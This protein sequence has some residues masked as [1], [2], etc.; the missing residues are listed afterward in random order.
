MVL[1]QLQGQWC[2][3]PGLTELCGALGWPN[4][5]LSTWEYLQPISTQS[6]VETTGSP[7]KA[8]CSLVQPE[9]GWH[10]LMAA[11][12]D[13]GDAAHPTIPFPGGS[14]LGVMPRYGE[15]ANSACPAWRE[16]YV[17]SIKC[18]EVIFWVWGRAGGRRWYSMWRGLN[19]FWNFRCLGSKSW[20]FKWKQRCETVI[21]H[22]FI[23][24]SGCWWSPVFFFLLRDNWKIFSYEFHRRHRTY[25]TFPHL[26][27]TLSTKEGI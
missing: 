11:D 3:R 27:N 2:G 13:P 26:Q 12:T 20:H 17:W 1:E 6:C 22:A 10:I 16:V 24:R 7:G 8:K 21:L 9:W 4:D 15:A 5:A 25:F 23:C 14:C 18:W 19:S